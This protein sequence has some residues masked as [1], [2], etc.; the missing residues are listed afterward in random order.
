MIGL[1]GRRTALVAARKA[2]GFTQEG[3]AEALHVDRSTVIRWEAG[4]YAPLPYLRPKLARL[5]GRSA[6]QLRDVLDG[7]P[8]GDAVEFGQEVER[9]LNWVDARAGWSVGEASRRVRG[10]LARGRAT[11]APPASGRGEIA[12]ALGAYYGG[13]VAGHALYAARAGSARTVTSVFTRPEWLGP[14]ALD[15][16]GDLELVP[17]SG[18]AAGPIDGAA[19]VRRLARVAEGDV[20]MTDAPIYRL[21]EIEAGAGGLVGRVE[22]ASFV[23]YALTADLLE[24][25][26]ADALT[27]GR[28]AKPGGLPLR[29][30][31]LPDLA[32]VL[33]LR[34][35]LCAGG[36]LALTAIARPAD[37]YRGEADY[38]LLVQERSAQVLN[39]AGK[40]SVIPK[41]FHGPLADYRTDARIGATLR[42]ELEEELFGRADV[43]NTAG[44]PRA[45]DPMHASRLS[46]PMR[47]LGERP[48]RMR[49]EC[50]GFG[51]NLVSGNYE[52]ATLVVIE[53][54]EFWSQF[55]GE[56][57]ANWEAAGLRQYSTRDAE[58]LVEL[59]GDEAWSNEGLFAFLQGLRRLREI[60]GSRVALPEIEL[61]C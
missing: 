45:A 59:V 4:E 42:R 56:V 11:Q 48:D 16:T 49:M 50:T 36:V 51:F 44:G 25:E 23:E 29:D 3:L 10:E 2:A 47:W 26:L 8:P 58:M 43:D 54:E 30:R 20:R 39:A 55:G 60:G 32:S 17:V 19:A 35:R 18:S 40:L 13:E 57:E 31:Y 22:L 37:P 27:A 21:T 46:R 5:L 61:G 6:D 14:C 9:A 52:F 7:D 12:A 24:G 1:A 28:S 41:G 53:D 33:D 38:L 15:T 34:N